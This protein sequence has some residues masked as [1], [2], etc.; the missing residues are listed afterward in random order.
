MISIT[1]LQKNEEETKAEAGTFSGETRFSFLENNK[2][3]ILSS[4]RLSKGKAQNADSQVRI[5]V[6]RG[7]A[8]P[9]TM[10][11]HGESRVQG[12]QLIEVICLSFNKFPMGRGE[13]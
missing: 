10:L 1:A 12:H 8:E 13:I 6:T 3:E 2:D 9:Q 7:L 11:I 4:A 5:P